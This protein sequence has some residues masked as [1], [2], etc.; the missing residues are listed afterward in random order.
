M[1]ITNFLDDTLKAIHSWSIDGK[2]LSENDVIS[3]E[4]SDKFVT[5]EC[6]K[7]S[8]KNIIWDSDLGASYIRTD[9]TIYTDR[10][11]FYLDE[12]DGQITWGCT[13]IPKDNTPD[14]TIT[15]IDLRP[16]DYKEG[17]K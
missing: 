14:T 8:A 1:T 2:Q 6:F 12:Y 11:I 15:S 5:W 13:I 17:E 16:K 10:V 3:V 9:I 4:V 7:Q